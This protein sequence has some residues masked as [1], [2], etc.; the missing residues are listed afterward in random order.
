MRFF[1]ISG[2]AIVVGIILFSVLLFSG[3]IS[4]GSKSS[5]FHCFGQS[6]TFQVVEESTH[7][8]SLFYL[9]LNNKDSANYLLNEVY[10]VGGNSKNLFSKISTK[11]TATRFAIDAN[12][13]SNN[14]YNEGYL[15]VKYSKSTSPD[16]NEEM[17]IECKGVVFS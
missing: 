2:L 10:W 4:D 13:F 8:S 11:G 16:A 14:E 15:L 5:V 9:A 7:F 3:V 17:K 12:V 1:I 6:P